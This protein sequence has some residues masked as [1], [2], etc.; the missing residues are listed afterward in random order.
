[1]HIIFYDYMLL[2]SQ[3]CVRHCLSLG[4]FFRKVERCTESAAIKGNYWE[5]IPEKRPLLYRDIE[6]FILDEYK[7]LVHRNGDR[8][9]KLMYGDIIISESRHACGWRECPNQ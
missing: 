8:S 3:N 4:Q 5:V 9:S 7:K 2:Q 6:V 1:M